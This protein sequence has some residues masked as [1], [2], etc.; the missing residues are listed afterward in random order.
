MGF[1]ILFIACR[2]QSLI[3]KPKQ[4]GNSTRRKWKSLESITKNKGESKLK[5]KLQNPNLVLFL[6]L[7]KNLNNRLKWSQMNKR[8]ISSKILTLNSLLEHGPPQ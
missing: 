3:P 8:K 1:I 5:Q 6:L 7:K 2:K 4:P